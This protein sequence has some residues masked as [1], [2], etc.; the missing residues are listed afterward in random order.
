MFTSVKLKDM[1][2]LLVQC[3]DQMETYLDKFENEQVDM[4][5][6][7]ARFATD[8]IGVCAFGLQ[9]NALAEEDSLFRK[10][11]KRIFELNIRNIGRTIFGSFLPELYKV[12]GYFF[13]DSLLDNFIIGITKDTMDYRRKN[14]INRKDFVDLLIAL[15]DEPSKVGDIGK[16]L[17]FLFSQIIVVHNYYRF[18]NIKSRCRIDR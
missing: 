12:V 5:E 18:F 13:R 8:V 6:I 11:G 1:F 14:G 16:N 3:A 15:K 10:M 4:R 2:Y 7:P 17:E 9:A